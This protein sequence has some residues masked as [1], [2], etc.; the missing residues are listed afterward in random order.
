MRVTRYKNW[1]IR[2]KIMFITVLSVILMLGGLFSFLLPKLETKITKEKR[3][4]TRHVVETAMAVLEVENELV[5][6]GKEPLAEAQLKA[7]N[8][9]SK[10]RYEKK[11][12]LWI[13]DLGNPPKMIMHPTLSA[14][15]GKVLD[16]PKFN[17]ATGMI[18]G[19]DGK[20]IPLD[21]K[22][23]FVAFAEVVQ[24]SG[25][26]FVN[27]EW[28]KPKEGGG[29][30]SELYPKLS[31]VKKFEPWGWVVGSGIYIDDVEKDISKVRWMF[32][33]LNG[34]MALISLLLAYFVSRGITRTLGY[35]DTNLDDMSKGGGDLTR[36]LA[37]EREDETG[38]LA[39]SFNRFLDNMKEIVQRINQNAVDVAKSADHL[40][41]T[42]GHIASGTERAS[43]QST[44]VAISCE[45]MAATSSEIAHN[46]IRTVEI[47]NRATQTA[48]D[49]SQVVSHA[50]SSIQ[51]IAHKVQESAKTVESLGVRSEQI[52][53]IVGTIEDIA[54][55]TNLL[56]LNAAIEAAR[57]GEQ[58]RGFAVVADEVRALAERTTKATREISEMI[59]SIQQETKSAVAAMEEGVHEVEK[60]TAEAGRSGEAL[61]EILA[62]V[63]ELT[64]QINQIATAAEQQSATTNEISKSMYE[65]TA[66][67][68]DASGSSQNTANAASQLAGMADEL[69]RI[70]AQF[71]M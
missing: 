45:E 29:T 35:V 69:K 41:E 54:D 64:S 60:G 34:L 66:V 21:G 11:E 42:A 10:M 55:Q 31:Y 6:S 33:A 18:E 20:E 48:Q 68:S 13:N 30:T 61:E 32:L 19:T 24:K 17:K 47:A 65:I 56:A 3:D 50:V 8:I 62:Q 22:N 63:A 40:N 43:T 57:A 52:G 16:D 26:G 70:V 23:L 7:A 5:K 59:K 58:G 36:R 12:Y 2:N 15:D 51:R 37:V 53:N 67:I 71:R 46:C 28:N 25:H 49:G 39:R 27:Y 38:S 44:S 4:A 9:L 1:K 14:L